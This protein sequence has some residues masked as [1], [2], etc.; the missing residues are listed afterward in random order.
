LTILAGSHVPQASDALGGVLD[1][2]KVGRS[3]AASQ[4]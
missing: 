2:E 1:I 4:E 3:L